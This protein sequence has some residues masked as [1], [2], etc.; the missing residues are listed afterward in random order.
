MSNVLT[1][2]DY[3]S[4]RRILILI[5]ANRKEQGTFPNHFVGEYWFMQTDTGMKQGTLANHLVFFLKFFFFKKK[6]K[7][8]KLVAELISSLF[9]KKTGK[10]GVEF[11]QNNFGWQ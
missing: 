2:S 3:K 9:F 11:C 10:E 8:K 7:K 4:F 1:V 5:H 6:K